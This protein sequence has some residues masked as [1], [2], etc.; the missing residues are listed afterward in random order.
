MLFYKSSVNQAPGKFQKGLKGQQKQVI[1]ELKPFI[2]LALAGRANTGKS[3][4][5]NKVTRGQSP[6]GEYPCT[7]LK[8]YYGQIKTFPFSCFLMDIPGI[9]KGTSEGIKKGKAFLRLMGRAKILL[10]FLNTEDQPIESLKEMEQELEAFDRTCLEERFAFRRKK[11]IVVLSKADRLTK[12]E[13]EKKLDE[14][15]Y[16]MSQSL[17]V[18]DEIF[19]EKPIALSL[20]TGE[21]VEKLLSVISRELKKPG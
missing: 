8:P 10:I 9:S 5:F 13:K 7:T 20:K 11:R 19:K 12:K 16:E 2:D 1:L 15:F 17:I 21:G 18:K 6:V 4:F 14:L 3:T